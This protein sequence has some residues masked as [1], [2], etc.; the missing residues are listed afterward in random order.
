MESR[1]HRQVS[2]LSVVSS[3][4]GEDI[5]DAISSHPELLRRVLFLSL[6][7]ALLYSAMAVMS[8]LT[9]LYPHTGFIALALI[10]LSFA[11]GSV[12]VPMVIYRLGIVACMCFGAFTFSTLI[13]SLNIHSTRA[14]LTAAVLNGTGA[15]FLWIGQGVFL[16]KMTSTS[17]IGGFTGIFFCLFNF[18][19]IT[20][21][22]VIAL[23]LQ[24]VGWEMEQV[25]WAML[26]VSLLALMLMMFNKGEGDNGM[27]NEFHMLEHYSLKQRLRV[28]YQVL[29]Q[30]QTLLLV[31]YIVC[32]GAALSY[33][34]GNLPLLALGNTH[35]I[36][37]V[38]IAFGIAAAL[39]AFVNGKMSDRFGMRPL[40][41]IHLLLIF[42]M[43]LLLALLF[44]TSVGLPRTLISTGPVA[45]HAL[46][47]VLGACFGYLDFLINTLINVSIAKHYTRHQM[48]FAFSIYRVLSCSAYSLTSLLSTLVPDYV[49]ISALMILTLTSVTC[50]VLFERISGE[51]DVKFE[52]GGTRID[53]ARVSVLSVGCTPSRTSVLSVADMIEEME[54]EEFSGY[55][56]IISP[57]EEDIEISPDLV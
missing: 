46:L 12:L 3:A 4:L 53:P 30:R 56:R 13:L 54:E 8:F 22:A 57:I 24:V 2:H 21:N 38:A 43:T 31:P 17:N 26:I 42:S 29:K 15:A 49:H 23:L 44:G 18:G 45:N 28:L 48:A 10:Q 52:I 41:V 5:N 47:I 50:Y 6:C 19:A 55:H 1:R 14:L 7:F 35:V 40:L 9:T 20:G 34:A 51:L 37:Y 39:S 36:S 25:I 16:T 27:Y 32:Q 33:S 11:I